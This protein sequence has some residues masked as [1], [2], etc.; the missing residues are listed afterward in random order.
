MTGPITV[1]RQ[2]VRSHLVQA[3]GGRTAPRMPLSRNVGRKKQQLS[4]ELGN[5]KKEWTHAHTQASTATTAIHTYSHSKVLTIYTHVNGNSVCQHAWTT[6][7]T[8]G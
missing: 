8:Y 4:S 2:M 6:V 7:L 3:H 1:A 5:R